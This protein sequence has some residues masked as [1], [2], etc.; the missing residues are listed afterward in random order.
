MPESSSYNARATKSSRAK[1][2][3]NM[4]SSPIESHSIHY[5]VISSN[6]LIKRLPTIE[7]AL[8][9]GEYSEE[10]MVAL[11]TEANEYYT[12][13][14]DHIL[15]FTELSKQMEGIAREIHGNSKAYVQ[16]LKEIQ[17]ETYKSK[18]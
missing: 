9:E 7:T 18:F 3:T 10:R 12:A 11:K 1:K 14:T 17:S 8:T 4:A 15:Q 2:K 16:V 6:M 13:M 5:K